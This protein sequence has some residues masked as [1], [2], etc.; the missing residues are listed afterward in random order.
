MESI[1]QKLS[2]RNAGDNKFGD[3]ISYYYRGVNNNTLTTTQHGVTSHPETKLTL[4]IHRDGNGGSI[5]FENNCSE[6][7]WSKR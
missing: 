2:L 5:L 3:K 6:K 7:R 4:H 1:R